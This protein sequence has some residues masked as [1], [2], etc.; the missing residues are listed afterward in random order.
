MPLPLLLLATLLLPTLLLAQGVVSTP[1]G[2]RPV[3]PE[4]NTL[5][6]PVDQPT[7]R[8]VK[9]MTVAPDGS[10]WFIVLQT[11][12]WDGGTFLIRVNKEGAALIG[13]DTTIFP[14]G[15]WKDAPPEA[16]RVELARQYIL[17]DV[18]AAGGPGPYLR[19]L[20]AEDRAALAPELLAAL[21]QLGVAL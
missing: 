1:K 17:P 10:T 12:E 8:W 21:R 19:S 18:K 15:Q 11:T 5:L 20:S 13:S 7:E 14:I 16:V 2:E 4:I 9:A 6:G 3:P